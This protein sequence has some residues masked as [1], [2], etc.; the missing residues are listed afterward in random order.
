MFYLFK[1]AHL[2][3]KK[4]EKYFC[5]PTLAVEEVENGMCNCCS[6]FIMWILQQQLFATLLQITIRTSFAVHMQLPL[7]HLSRSSD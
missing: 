1:D 4:S 7:A 2:T 6:V 5:M 3:C